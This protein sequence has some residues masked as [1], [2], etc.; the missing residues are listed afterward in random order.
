MHPTDCPEFEYAHHPRRA[1]LQDQLAQIL[2]SL[3][4]GNLD[5]V[6]L[7]ADSRS[8]HQRLFEELTP[9]GQAYYAGHYRGEE[10]RCLKHYSVGVSSDSRVGHPPHRVLGSMAA[11]ADQVRTGLAVLDVA[12]EMP[13]A[14]VAREDKLLYIVVFACQVF[15]LFL[16]I[17]PYANGNGHA[18]RFVVWAI[19]GRFGY[20]PRSWP[21]DPRPPDPPYTQLILEYRS[22]NPEPL[23]SHLLSTLV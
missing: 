15:E 16:R 10:F 2:L 9:A 14:Q 17:H 23:E 19:L 13:D 8:V 4:S 7:A 20:W 11:V 6:E 5:K 21:I 18:A 22:G 3:R 1:V 12:T